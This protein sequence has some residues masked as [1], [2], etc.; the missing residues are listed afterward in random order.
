LLIDHNLSSIRIDSAAKRRA[1][2]RFPIFLACLRLPERNT[3]DGYRSAICPGAIANQ[4]ESED[5]ASEISNL[6]FGYYA[7]DTN[8]TSGFLAFACEGCI[9]NIAV[10][11]DT[12]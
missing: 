3:E 11:I 5:S 4:R 6:M 2:C 7:K 8:R 10:G 9:E 1:N 12:R